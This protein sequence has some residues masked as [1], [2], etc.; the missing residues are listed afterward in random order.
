M[1]DRTEYEKALELVDELNPSAHVL[2]KAQQQIRDPNIEITDL[3]KT[4]NADPTITADIIRIS[5][6]AYY[7]YATASKDLNTAISR[8]GFQELLKLVGLAV[9]KNIFNQDLTYYNMSAM[10]Y[11]S[12]SVSVA[13]LMEVLG[14]AIS[15]DHQLFYTVGLLSTVGKLVINQVLEILGEETI[16]EG[17]NIKDWEKTTLGFDN[18]FAGAMILKRWEFPTEITNAILHQYKKENSEEET[19]VLNTLAFSRKIITQTG[20]GFSNDNLEVD[21]WMEEYLGKY[22]I[23]EEEL[24]NGVVV[25][26]ENYEIIKSELDIH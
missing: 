14:K 26:T 8:L 9:S 18:A 16:F 10:D 3:V 24:I 1:A 6:S 15:Q 2:S 17:S 5:N 21:E 20:S 19:A 22:Y 4:L 25:A 23:D 7:S 13:L 12:E 11:W